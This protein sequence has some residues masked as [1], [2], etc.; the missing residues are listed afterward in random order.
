MVK[1]FL[2]SAI[3]YL[4]LSRLRPCPYDHLVCIDPST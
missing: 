3:P 1:Y 4:Y 2:A